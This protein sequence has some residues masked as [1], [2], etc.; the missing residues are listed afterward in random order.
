MTR[1]MRNERDGKQKYSIFNNRKNQ[2]VK[3][4]GVGERNEHFVI[5][6]K[7]SYARDA[8][9]AYAV[10]AKADG[11]VEYAEDVQALA[12]RSGPLSPFCKRPD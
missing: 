3:D 2:P 1:L 4:D 8:L 10:A 6:L 11:N 5:M 12:N 7:D 9:L